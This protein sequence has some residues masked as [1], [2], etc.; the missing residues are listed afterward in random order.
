M[1][2]EHASRSR[3]AS[4]L[5]AATLVGHDVH[6]PHFTVAGLA[7]PTASDSEPPSNLLPRQDR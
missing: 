2:T 3:R 7:V 6:P 4:S 1:R 5:P